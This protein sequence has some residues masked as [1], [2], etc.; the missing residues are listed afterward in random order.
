MVGSTH[1]SHGLFTHREYSF[2]VQLAELSRG[3][4]LR[5]SREKGMMAKKNAI[6][7]FSNCLNETLSPYFGRKIVAATAENPDVF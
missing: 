1:T 6:R 4:G 2:Y 3:V 5:N 7:T